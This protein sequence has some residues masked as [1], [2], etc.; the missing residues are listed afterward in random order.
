VRPHLCA[1]GFDDL[2]FRSERLLRSTGAEEVPL[3]SKC[4]KLNLVAYPDRRPA[5]GALQQFTSDK[6]H[7]KMPPSKR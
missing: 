7:F 2:V 6:R 5:I 3:I 4:H 1:G